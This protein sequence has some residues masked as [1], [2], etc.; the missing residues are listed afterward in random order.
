MPTTYL[1]HLWKGND[2]EMSRQSKEAKEREQELEWLKRLT[3]ES[4]LE[5]KERPKRRKKKD[6][7]EEVSEYTLLA[8]DLWE[9]LDKKTRSNITKEEWD[10]FVNALN[11]SDDL[12]KVVW[13]TLDE[14]VKLQIV[15][16]VWHSFIKMLNDDLNSPDKAMVIP[17]FGTFSKAMH[18]GHPLNLNIKGGSDSISDYETFKFKPDASYKAQILG[19]KH[20]K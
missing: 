7:A 13:K 1:C 9:S 2:N 15:E 12:S 11:K 18:K 16:S 8:D 19:R 14:D 17:K 6:D 20:A 3:K 5:I 4:D 10:A